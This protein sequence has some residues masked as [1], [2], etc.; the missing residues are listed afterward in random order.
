M[1]QPQV[2]PLTDA[3]LVTAL[4]KQ[5]PYHPSLRVL[6]IEPPLESGDAI[7]FIEQPQSWLKQAVATGI[8]LNMAIE[9]SNKEFRQ[10]QNM[11]EKF[12]ESLRKLDKEAENPKDNSDAWAV[13]NKRYN[14]ILTE[15]NEI[16]QLAQTNHHKLIKSLFRL[17][18]L[19]IK[20]AKT[21]PSQLKRHRK[22]LR[23]KIKKLFTGPDGTKRFTMLLNLHNHDL[24]T[25]AQFGQEPKQEELTS[26]P[27]E[28]Q[29]K[30]KTIRK[31][32][33][34]QL[35]TLTSEFVE[36]ITQPITRKTPDSI[37]HSLRTQF[38]KLDQHTSTEE[39]MALSFERKRNVGHELRVAVTAIIFKQRL[40]GTAEGRSTTP[41]PEPRH[42]E[43]LTQIE[44]LKGTDV[45]AALSESSNELSSWAQEMLTIRTQLNTL[46]EA[47]EPQFETQQEAIDDLQCS[48][49]ELTALVPPKDDSKNQLD[50]ELDH[51]SDA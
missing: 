48:L 36:E 50:V 34:K 18:K 28:A 35:E 45:Q 44:H 29:D 39:E 4:T 22:V 25:V 40:V 49:N 17:R 1:A 51:S 3:L 46:Q 23:Q 15:V 31:K 10:L 11:I 43:I 12:K 27:K 30:L 38:A 32:Q 13:Y 8:T 33:Y 5:T 21:F 7:L 9:Q 16:L 41:H 47:I 19:H 24:H 2:P 37:R 20:L 42:N 6:G 14:M 26:L